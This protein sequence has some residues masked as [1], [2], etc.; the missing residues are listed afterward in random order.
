MYCGL[1]T[2]NRD[3]NKRVALYLPN[4]VSV[5]GHY[6]LFAKILALSFK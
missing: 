5:K 2:V 3:V 1:Q 4:R 6:A